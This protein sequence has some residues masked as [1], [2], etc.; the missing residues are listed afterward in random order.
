MPMAQLGALL[1]AA[2]HK[3]YG[4]A[5]AVQMFG[6]LVGGDP[7]PQGLGNQGIALMVLDPEMFG[8]RDAYGAG[9]ADL[10][11]RLKTSRSN[12]EGEQVRYPGEGRARRRRESLESGIAVPRSVLS[13]IERL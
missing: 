6:I 8:S 2:A 4:L 12:S 13:L 10:L 11:D 1:P 7:V 3:G 9:M 5:L